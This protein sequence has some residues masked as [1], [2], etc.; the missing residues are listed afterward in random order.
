MWNVVIN[1]EAY[2]TRLYNTI[3]LLSYLPVM[4]LAAAAAIIYRRDIRNW[5]ILVVPALYLTAVHMVFIGS[6]RYRLP[7]MPFLIVLCAAAF[8]RLMCGNKQMEQTPCQNSQ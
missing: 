5:L 1:Y 4:C 3:S 2:R 7:A 8:V 6:I